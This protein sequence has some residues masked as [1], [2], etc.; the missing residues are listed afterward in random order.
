MMK[1]KQFFTLLLLL[2]LLGASA[3]ESFFIKSPDRVS[4]GE[5]FYVTFTLKDAEASQQSLKAPQINGCTLLY[6]PTVSTQYSSQFINGVAS[7]SMSTDYTFFYRADKEGTYSIP[8]ATVVTQTGKRLSTSAKNLTIVKGSA[9]Q[10]SSPSAPSIDDPNT[11]AYGNTVNAKDVFVRIIL[12][13]SSA[14][15]QEAIECTIKLFTT[16]SIDE[17]LPTTQ[18]N[19]D[20]FLVEDIDMPNTVAYEQING[21]K[22][23]TAILKKCILF[24]QK[25]GKLTINS[26]NYDLTITQYEKVDLG[27][28]YAYQPI[29]K[30]IK[31]TSNQASV[32]IKPL[33]SQQPDGF[34]GAVGNY[35]VD[36]TLSHSSM[37]TNE[38]AT[39]I[40][41][42]SGTGN[43]KYLK[44]PVV[45]F[46]VEFEQY[47]PQNSLEASVRGNN[48]SG[49]SQWDLSFIPKEVGDFTISVPDF[50]YFNPSTGQYVTIPGKQFAVKVAQG[51]SNAPSDRKGIEAKNTDIRYIHTNAKVQDKTTT[52]VNS[53]TYYWIIVVLVFVL[54]AVTI[55]YASKRKELSADIGALRLAK[56][57]KVARKRLNIAQKCI[58]NNDTENFYL[59]ALKALNGYLTDKLG[60]DAADLSRQSIQET[61]HHYDIDQHIIDDTIS[62]LDACEMSRY[63]PVVADNDQ[64]QSIYDRICQIIN[65]LEKFKIKK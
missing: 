52:F 9:S 26:G 43:I 21:Q 28:H 32:D 8:T 46:P 16:Y 48:V 1:K 39:L 45:D 7:Q 51:V 29:Q 12:S 27:F 50:V 59:E 31:V 49:T 58:K 63:A 54:L 53:S 13:K 25:Q 42:V 20:G 30:K 56:A 37:R 36:C 40:Y 61:M 60:I 3:K 47:S 55:L 6:G 4:T 62:I 10:S 19:F 2:T 38:T 64:P 65:V 24:P 15:E 35:T 11:Q 57:N 17:F 22:Y 44:D 33:P 34:N 14:F 18:P 5:K 23:A 41:K